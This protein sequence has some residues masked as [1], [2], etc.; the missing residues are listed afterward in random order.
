MN[1]DASGSTVP[2]PYHHG[3]LRRSLLDEAIKAIGES[4]S[5]EI[6][7]RE[8]ARRAGVSHAAPAYHFG[9]KAGLLTALAAEGYM[10]LAAR[11]TEVAET[12]GSF[13]EIGVAY[14]RFALDHPQ[15]F[16]VMFRPELVNADDPALLEA[17]R[18]A[19]A[20]LFG[21]IAEMDRAA[22]PIDVLHAGIA[23][24]SLVHG[25]ATLWMDG[26][27]PSRLGEDPERAARKIVAMLFRPLSAPN[28]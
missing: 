26:A 3:D 18:A 27:L 21:P 8:L 2:R 10:L 17:K 7:L 20:M 19:R 23:A 16:D 24:W 5:A 4:G 13:A 28:E 22:P 1:K 15:Y 14:V 12:T 11:L 9:D 6:S 25:F